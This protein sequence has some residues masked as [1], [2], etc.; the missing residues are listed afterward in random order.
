VRKTAAALLM[1][2]AVAAPATAAFRADATTLTWFGVRP[3]AEA[4]KYRDALLW[5]YEGQ[6][7]N[8]LLATSARNNVTL[9]DVGGGNKEL[10][11]SMPLAAGNAWVTALVAVP[12]P[13]ASTNADKRACAD[14]MIRADIK[15]VWDAYDAHLRD[16][17]TPLTPAP[18]L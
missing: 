2:A 12:C 17:S 7:L 4:D 9:T 6:P 1:L 3:A 10:A 5:Y 15:R 11:I 13:T 14:P 16:Q 18:D 8:G